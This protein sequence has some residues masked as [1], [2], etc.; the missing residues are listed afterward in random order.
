MRPGAAPGVLKHAYG[1]LHVAFRFQETKFRFSVSC[2]KKT[3]QGVVYR[4]LLDA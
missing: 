3:G 2:G 1:F 4:Y